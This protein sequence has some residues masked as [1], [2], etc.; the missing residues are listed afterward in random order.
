MITENW[1]GVKRMSGFVRVQVQYLGYDIDLPGVT[2]LKP[3]DDQATWIYRKDFVKK[4]IYLSGGLEEARTFV[5]GAGVFRMSL[6]GY[7]VLEPA[8]LR[9]YGIDPGA[10]EAACEAITEYLVQ[11]ARKFG[12]EPVLI[13]G[14]SSTGVDAA[15]IKVGKTMN[16]R[17][18][19]CSCPRYMLWVDDDDV[20]VWVANSSDEYADVYVQLLHFL[21]TTGGRAQSLGHDIA[22]ACMY[23]TPVCIFDVIN[24]VAKT[25]VPP[26][27]IENGVRK[28]VNTAAAFA[29]NIHTVGRK[30]TAAHDILPVNGWDTAL[31][32]LA[33][34]MENA[35]LITKP[36][37]TRFSMTTIAA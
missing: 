20:P 8:W 12:V 16:V 28:V 32:E 1:L 24:A 17:Q 27:I 22:A 19:G 18:L 10:Y 5:S 30:R 6:N 4:S 15:I 35:A 7:S 9:Q 2:L 31:A 13:H 36:L 23:D 34:R 3:S 33:I 25:T 21:V 29:R 11:R 37:T 14:A 26:F